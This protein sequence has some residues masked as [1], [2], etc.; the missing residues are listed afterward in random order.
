MEAMDVID[1]QEAQELVA[2]LALADRIETRKLSKR[3]VY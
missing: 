1:A 3:T 2:R